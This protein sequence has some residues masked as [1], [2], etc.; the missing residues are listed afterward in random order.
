MERLFTFHAA[1]QP[2]RY[3]AAASLTS[4]SP[5]VAKFTPMDTY[6]IPRGVRVGHVHLM[7][8]DVDRA[9]GF[10]RELLGFEDHGLLSRGTTASDRLPR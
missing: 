7:V 4:R 2:P 8:S 9:L 1:P 6:G 5:K 10:Y 3:C